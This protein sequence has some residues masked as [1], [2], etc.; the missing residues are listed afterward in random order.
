MP[1]DIESGGA[2]MATRWLGRLVFRVAICIVS[3][4]VLGGLFLELS[5]S[6]GRITDF[7]DSWTPEVPPAE[8]LTSASA[9]AGVFTHERSSNVGHD[10]PL[11]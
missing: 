11:V 1:T 10:R 8:I 6:R 4:G 7:R 3:L 9:L 2:T 5:A